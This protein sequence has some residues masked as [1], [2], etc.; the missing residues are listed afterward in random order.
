MNLERICVSYFALNGK[1]VYL[2]YAYAAVLMGKKC[3]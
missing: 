1:S 3:L 2:K